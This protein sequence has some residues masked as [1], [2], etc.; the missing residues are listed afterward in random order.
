MFYKQ[1]YCCGFNIGDFMFNN[2]I[3]CIRG[4]IR[5]AQEYYKSIACKLIALLALLILL[6]SF[7]YVL[8]LHRSPLNSH[9]VLAMIMPFLWFMNRDIRNVGVFACLLLAISMKSWIATASMMLTLLIIYSGNKKMFLTII[10]LGMTLLVSLNINTKLNDDFSGRW[11]RYKYTLSK[12]HNVFWG[13]GHQSFIKLS[14]NRP[15]NNKGLLVNA[16]HSDFLQIPFEWGIVRAIPVY[17]VMGMP[18]FFFTLRGLENRIMLSSYVN[19]LIQ[20]FFDWPFHRAITGA[21]AVYIFILIYS[22][23]IQE[24]MS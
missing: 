24:R 21:F 5:P 13:E 22:K 9:L 20:F 15:E 3:H 2:S 16:V 18:L 14:E 6:Q 10:L 8:L 4:K 1:N 23:I 12:W 11:H 19:I 17:I 7:F